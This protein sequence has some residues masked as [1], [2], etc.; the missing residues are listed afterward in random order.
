MSTPNPSTPSVSRIMRRTMGPNQVDQSIR[1]AIQMCWQMLPEDRQTVA[2][3]ELQIRR[4]VDRAI[5]DYKD[6]C[7]AFD[8]PDDSLPDPISV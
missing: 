2:E 7:A 6:D 8:M 5:Q 3:L 4:M 1:M